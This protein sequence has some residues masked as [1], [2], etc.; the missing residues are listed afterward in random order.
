[1]T[2]PGFPPVSPLVC[3]VHRG[4]CMDWI[5]LVV[6]GFH[7]KGLVNDATDRLIRLL[8]DAFP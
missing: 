5:S 6:D 1:M 4:I 7:G 3:D 2:S 8:S